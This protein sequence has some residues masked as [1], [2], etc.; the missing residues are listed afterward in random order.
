MSTR[1][2]VTFNGTDLT[3]LAIV[4]GWSTAALPKE[5]EQA[6]IPG[7][8]GSRL[9]S[10]T[11]A[12][13]EITVTLTVR[14]A[15]PAA[16]A[17]SIRSLL[18]ILDVDEPKPLARSIDNGLYYLAIP[19]ATGD[20]THNRTSDSFEVVFHC[21]DPA[22]Y[23]EEKTATIGT[24]STTVTIGGNYPTKPLVTITSAKGN[25]SNVLTLTHTT[26]SEYMRATVSSSGSSTVSFDCDKHVLKVN[27]TTQM[28]S[29]LSDWLE[30]EPGRNVLRL[31]AGS[32]TVT[33]KWIERWL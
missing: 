12:A 14:G 18:G 32:G 30:L 3:A 2:T 33:M 17:A 1:T 15:T 31:S 29:T 26:K 21:P 27:N 28:L 22:M 25:T 11:I 16:R 20:I 13:R 4:S 23:G 9:V 24:S 5:L 19:T 10:T 8:D 7:M 6:T